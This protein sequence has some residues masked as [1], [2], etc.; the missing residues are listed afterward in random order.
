[1]RSLEF[2]E[3]PFPAIRLS[4]SLEEKASPEEKDEISFVETQCVA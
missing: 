2:A 3:I 1:M 4:D